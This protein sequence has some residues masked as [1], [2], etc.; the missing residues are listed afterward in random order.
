MRC[1]LA[2][3]TIGLG[4]APPPAP[5]PTVASAGE[6]PRTGSPVTHL[7]TAGG[8]LTLMLG[9]LSVIGGAGRRRTRGRRRG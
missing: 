8:G 1:R 4:C 2:A 9:G 3:G 5:G 6:L 7:A